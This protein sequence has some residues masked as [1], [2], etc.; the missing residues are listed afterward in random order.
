MIFIYQADDSVLSAKKM[1]FQ[2]AI[3]DNIIEENC[4]HYGRSL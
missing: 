4:Q 1:N 2:N 3:I